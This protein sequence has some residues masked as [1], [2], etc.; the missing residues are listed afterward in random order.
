MKVKWGHAVKLGITPK[1]GRLAGEQHVKQEHQC[2]GGALLCM[3]KEKED[4]PDPWQHCWVC[5]TRTLFFC[6]GCKNY[7]CHGIKQAFNDE[8]IKNLMK[9]TKDKAL[10]ANPPKKAKNTYV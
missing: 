8:K 1:K 4:D 5:G 6:T 7:L 10:K 2:M 3:M 9:N